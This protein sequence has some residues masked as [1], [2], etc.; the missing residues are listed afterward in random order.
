MSNS[1]KMYDIMYETKSTSTF[2][3]VI[4]GSVCLTV[5]D[6]DKIELIETKYYFSVLCDLYRSNEKMV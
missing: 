5:F 3:E 6:S 1:S 4:P 2:A